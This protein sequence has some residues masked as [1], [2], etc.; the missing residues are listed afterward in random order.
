MAAPQE[1][2]R[3]VASEQTL[4]ELASAARTVQNSIVGVAPPPEVARQ[5]TAM[6]EQLATLLQPFAIDPDAPSTWD[7]LHRMTPTRL[8]APELH[9]DR[10]DAGGLLGRVTFGQLYGGAN[11]AVHGGA[12]PLIF[13]EGFAQVANYNGQ[14]RT[15]SLTVD[16]RAVT[17]LGREL[18]LRCW[19]ER[20]EG[21]KVYV[22][23]T[24]HDGETLTVD[25]HALFVRLRPGAS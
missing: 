24:L 15:A 5:A 1:Q 18:T 9:R 13:D 6:L 25:A 20:D 7:D 14:T 19:L 10:L 8:L 16:Y 2:D 23:G 11:G 12:I 21:R 4:R 22:R 3:E 17:P